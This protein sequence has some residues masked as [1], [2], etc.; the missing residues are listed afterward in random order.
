M[1]WAGVARRQHRSA[2]LAHPRPAARQAIVTSVTKVGESITFSAAT[3]IAAVLTLLLASFSFYSDLGVPFAIAIGVIL[4]AGLTL[5]PALLSIRLS[6]L[7]VKRTIFRAIFGRPKLLPWDIQGSG[8]TGV[9]GR[10]AARIVRHPAPTPGRRRGGLRRARRSACS[11]TRPAASAADTTAPAGSDSAAGTTLL[12]RY[13]PQSSANPTNLI[14][15]FSK[16]VW[17]NPAPLAKGTSRAPGEPAVHAGDRAAEPVGATLTPAQFT[18]LHA[19][20]GPAKALPPVPPPGTGVPPAAYQLYRATANFVSAGRPDRAVS[21]PGSRP[22][23]PATPRR[24][25]AV[26]A[27]RAAT[28]KVAEVD[29][30]GRLRRGGRGTRRCTTSAPSPTATCSGSSRSRSW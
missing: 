12:A 29:R 24:L 21:R 19:A 2:D 1:P 10:V 9:W 27:I 16:P 6:L 30:R 11:A 4:I 20:L 8:K 15:R 18:A 14:F 3:V 17:T 25:N 22:A 13:F 23:I 28:T 7:G 26:P 5:L